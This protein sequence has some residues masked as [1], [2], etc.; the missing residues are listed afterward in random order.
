[1]HV[2]RSVS[3]KQRRLRSQLFPVTLC[4]LGIKP[5]PLGLS[6]C[7][8]SLSHHLTSPQIKLTQKLIMNRKKESQTTE[9]EMLKSLASKTKIKIFSSLKQTSVK[10]A[11][12]RR[13]ELKNFDWAGGMGL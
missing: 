12:F 10:A 5:T 8:C 4:D 2:Y 11:S 9:R 7:P 6:V 1:M 13:V 3:V